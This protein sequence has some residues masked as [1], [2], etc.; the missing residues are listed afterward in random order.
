MSIGASNFTADMKAALDDGS[1]SQVQADDEYEDDLF[2]D[3]LDASD[4]SIGWSD[5]TCVEFGNGHE[6]ACSRSW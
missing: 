5:W 2:D 3:A 4:R 1:L 6:H